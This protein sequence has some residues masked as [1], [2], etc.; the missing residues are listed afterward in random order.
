MLLLQLLQSAHEFVESTPSAPLLSSAPLP[1]RQMLDHARDLITADQAFDP[2]VLTCLSPASLSRTRAIF[3]V[4]PER[5]IAH[6]ASVFVL[7][8]PLSHTGSV[9]TGFVLLYRQHAWL[10]NSPP[11]LSSTG[12][13]AAWLSELPSEGVR[14]CMSTPKCTGPPFGA[15]L[16]L[17]APA[18]PRPVLLVSLGGE[19]EKR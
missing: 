7:H 9:T 12:S 19:E 5:D 10:V 4:V 8:P 17:R 15:L 13:V 18:H 16:G 2:L 6:S 3:L 1:F 11:L 14:V